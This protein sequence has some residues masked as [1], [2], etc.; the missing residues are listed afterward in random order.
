MLDG[1]DD[2]DGF[3]QFTQYMGI[4]TAAIGVAWIFINLL[5]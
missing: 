5:R 1:F 2:L 3:V 4:A